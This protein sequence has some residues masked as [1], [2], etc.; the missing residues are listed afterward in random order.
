MD[1]AQLVSIAGRTA[2]ALLFV[3]AG[4]AKFLDPNPFL[5]HMAKE[6][7]P[8]F[9]LYAAAIVEI[10]AGGALIAGWNVRIAAGALSLFCLSTAF[11]IHLHLSDRVERTQF[12]KDIALAGSLA[13]L[14]AGV[15]P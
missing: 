7:V 14:S 1:K 4:I 8:G 9:L 11:V 3:L 15:A 5:T 2:L 13:V 12:V 6:H 10:V